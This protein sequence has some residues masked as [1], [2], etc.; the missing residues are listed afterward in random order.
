MYVL[1]SF[2]NL[3]S[4][5]G[6]NVQ[7]TNATPLLIATIPIN[8]DNTCIVNLDIIGTSTGGDVMYLSSKAVILRVTSG[9]ITVVGSTTVANVKSAGASAWVAAIAAS[10]TNITITVT[11]AAATTINWGVSGSVIGY[12]LF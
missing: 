4:I 6:A 11:G 8:F 5:N 10:G 1:T 2:D 12:R 3:P 7:T 9:N